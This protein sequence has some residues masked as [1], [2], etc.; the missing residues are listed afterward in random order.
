MDTD[1]MTRH[2]ADKA[3]LDREEA[4]RAIEA[5]LR[6]LGQR[7]TGPEVNDLAGQLPTDF[8]SAMLDVAAE[9]DEAE[10]FDREEFVRRVSADFDAD[11]ETSLRA[12]KAVF[13]TIEAGISAGEW[14]DLLSQ[15]PNDYDPLFTGDK[16]SNHTG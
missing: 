4:R 11:D 7:V 3:Q 16:P 1:T 15:L 9:S 2:V 5:T 12:V 6:T 14:G 13:E 8:G 10:P